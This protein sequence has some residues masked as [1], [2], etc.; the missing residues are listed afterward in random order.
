MSK[1]RLTAMYLFMLLYYLTLFNTKKC[2]VLWCLVNISVHSMRKNLVSFY[3]QQ[4]CTSSAAPNG[5]FYSLI[6]ALEL[7]AL[8]V[9][10]MYP[11]SC[12]SWVHEVIESN[13][14]TT[15]CILRKIYF[16]ISFV[17]Y[18]ACMCLGIFCVDFTLQAT[19]FQ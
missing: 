2:L 7:L 1:Y 16:G 5:A 14:F 4:S 12:C 9:F 11:A 17:L 3:V 8:F 6:Y 18:L 15:K 10:Q 13:L 19:F